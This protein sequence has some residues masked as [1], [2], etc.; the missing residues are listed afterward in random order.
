MAI[1]ANKKTGAFVLSLC[2]SAFSLGCEEESH[3]P[4]RPVAPPSSPII[5]LTPI[6]LNNT[7]ADL[8]GMPRDSEGWP[9]RPTITG[10]LDV[11][12]EYE[13]G[14]SAQLTDAEKATRGWPWDYPREV[15]LFGFEGMA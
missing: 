3:T 2:M 1:K 11:D 9:S 5:A 12:T 8:L 15:G 4:A 7:I 6:E 14:L 10:T 13:D